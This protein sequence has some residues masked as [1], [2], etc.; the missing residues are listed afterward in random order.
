MK[1]KIGI[2]T[3]HKVLNFGSALQAY[4]LQKK[5][6]DL[7]FDAEII[8][9]IFKPCNTNKGIKGR[10]KKNIQ[11]ILDKILGFSNEKESK[12]FT[13]FYEK[14]F[15]LSNKKYDSKIDF[16]NCPIYDLY[17]TGSDQV[18]NPRYIKNDPTFMFS[19][20]NDG[21]KIT[22]Y[23]SSLATDKIPK[24]LEKMYFTY[25]SRYS[26]ISVREET[27]GVLLKKLLGK[28]IE[29][30][31][32]PTL[33]LS[34]DEW[35][36]MAKNS[37]CEIPEPY[38]LVYNLTY[39]YN[40]Y[41]NVQKIIDEVQS[42]LGHRVIY[43]QGRYVDLFR[44]KSTVIRDIG[45]EDFLALFLN[46]KFVI[47]TSFHG[48]AFS[49]NFGIPFFSIVKSKDNE[50]DRMMCLLNKLGLTHRA[51]AYNQSS[52]NKELLTK[53]YISNKLEHYRSFSLDVL[54]DMCKI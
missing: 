21:S 44:K 28:T 24:S 16:N 15:A 6:L 53:N 30:V 46:A 38:I 25:L 45:P 33:L 34:K 39:S 40:P 27:G 49:I 11:F 37:V 19:F 50:D 18:W 4:A 3:M 32:D 12:C 23:A 14:Y 13:R 54:N 1:K 26:R 9:Y 41:P 47:T 36:E 5:I 7:G 31:C 10:L 48:T 8:D 51:I 2:I 20:V 52:F 17:M 42:L 29:H 43:L 35:L 22:S